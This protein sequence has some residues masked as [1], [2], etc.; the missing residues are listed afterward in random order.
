VQVA[1]LDESNLTVERETDDPNVG[2]LERVGP[3]NVNPLIRNVFT[4]EVRDDSTPLRFTFDLAR[5]EVDGR[6][7]LDWADENG[8]WFRGQSE[9]RRTVT[10]FFL[11]AERLG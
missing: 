6:T 11:I 2:F 1:S 8:I 4:L 3:G 10:S 5:L 7:V 9:D